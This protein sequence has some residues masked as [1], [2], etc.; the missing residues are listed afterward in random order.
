MPPILI[1]LLIKAA[2]SIAVELLKKSGVISPVEAWG[3]KTGTHVIQ[4]VENIQV[5]PEYPPP[6]KE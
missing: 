6:R 1:Q 3:I 5:Y 4:A 2:I